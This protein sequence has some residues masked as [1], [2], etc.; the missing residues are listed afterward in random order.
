M[1]IWKKIDPI[2]SG[3]KCGLNAYIRY[4]M[5]RKQIII[6]SLFM[7]LCFTAFSKD[8]Y[9]FG[10]LTIRDGLSSGSITCILQDSRGFIWIGTENGLN[11]YDGYQITIYR[12]NPQLANSIG[13]NSIRSLFEDSRNNLWIG[14]KGDGL[15][16]LNLKT[17]QFTSF[18]HQEHENSISYN[19]VAGIVEDEQGKLWIAVDRG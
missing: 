12:H 19:D 7:V 11:K 8:A 15:S 18:R 5:K 10:Q 9:N 17:G 16:R 3:N 2:H 4:M 1:Y 13:G 14:L 6:I